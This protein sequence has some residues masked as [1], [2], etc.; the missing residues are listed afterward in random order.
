MRTRSC[1]TKLL[2]TCRTEVIATNSLYLEHTIAYLWPYM[3]TDFNRLFST[4]R[5]YHLER[6]TVLIRIYF[7]LLLVYDLF[8]YTV[9]GLLENEWEGQ[10]SCLKLGQ[11]L[12]VCPGGVRKKHR[13]IQARKPICRQGYEFWIYGT[14]KKKNLCLWDRASLE[15]R[16]KQPTRCNKFRLLIFLNQLYMFRATNSPIFRIAFW[17]YIQ[18]K[19]NPEDGRVCRPKL[20]ELI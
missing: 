13:H 15:Q 11:L 8:D 2:R 7:V 1:F 20:I 14:R 4:H 10:R 5:I 18:S 6:E 3:S 9:I 19:S 17:M 16:C 12:N